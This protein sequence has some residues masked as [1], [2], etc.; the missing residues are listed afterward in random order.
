MPVSLLPVASLHLYVPQST[1]YFA[2]RE[3]NRTAS[4]SCMA[5]NAERLFVLSVLLS[6]KLGAQ[7]SHARKINAGPSRAPIPNQ[8]HHLNPT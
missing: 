2:R 7:R 5:I 1:S 6:Y 8:K 4:Q 3:R